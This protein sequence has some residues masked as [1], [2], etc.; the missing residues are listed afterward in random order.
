MKQHHSAE[1]GQRPQ[2]VECGHQAGA[3]AKPTAPSSNNGTPQH[4]LA[5]NVT[6]PGQG[7]AAGLSSRALT[8]CLCAF[9]EVDQLLSKLGCLG[10]ALNCLAASQVNPASVYERHHMRDLGRIDGD[11]PTL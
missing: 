1:S 6:R 11:V 2:W 10:V 3:S 9:V 5:K 7:F 4:A 8:G